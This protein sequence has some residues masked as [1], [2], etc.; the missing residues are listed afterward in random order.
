MRRMHTTQRSGPNREHDFASRTVDLFRAVTLAPTRPKS[1]RPRAPAVDGRIM[2]VLKQHLT[3]DS[4]RYATPH[5][6]RP[7]TH[8]L[9][10]QPIDA[11]FGARID[12]YQCHGK[13]HQSPSH[14]RQRPHRGG[15]SAGPSCLMHSDGSGHNLILPRHAS[16]KGEHLQR[17]AEAAAG[18]LFKKWLHEKRQQISPTTFLPP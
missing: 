12:P 5:G 11:A 3:C 10:H 15:R 7:P 18:T 8:L 14:H 2:S 4:E 13:A 9:E 16:D 1:Q 17:T 6:T